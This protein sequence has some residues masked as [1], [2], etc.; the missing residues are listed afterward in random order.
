MIV[1]DGSVL[2]SGPITGVGRSFLDTLAAYL[3]LT[4]HAC[5]L[6][7]PRTAP[8]VELDLRVLRVPHGWWARE[9]ALPRLLR[10][11]G[12]T[13]YH[14]PV[15][16]LPPWSRG[17]LVATVH[18]VP[19]RH[20]PE[21]ADAGRSWR[22]RLAARRAWRRAAAILVPSEATRADCLADGAPPARLHVVPHGVRA[23]DPPASPDALRGPFLVLGD[24]RPRKNLPRLRR[25]HAAA[26]AQRPDLPELCLIGPQQPGGYLA[27][28]EKLQRLRRARAVV[29]VSLLE[30]YGLPV[31]EAFAHG[32]PVVTSNLGALAELAGDAALTVDP[33]DEAAIAD[34]LIRIHDDGALRSA[35]RE[36]G[37]ARAAGRRPAAAAAAWARVHA[38]LLARIANG[39][40]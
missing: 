14:S 10:R 23:P 36:R 6:L 8:E 22:H 32:V 21:F 33:V 18:D 40:G 15:A 20:A 4:R 39:A 34:A 19:W 24:A 2:G 28:D 16:A 25:A 38:E 7:L 35:L 30:G 27:E 12:A 11:V 31:L 26:R 1:F 3:Q 17:P 9:F 13:L 5:V 37:L 29:H